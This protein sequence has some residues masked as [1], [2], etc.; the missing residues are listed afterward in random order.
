[1]RSS[2]VSED[3]TK[4]QTADVVMTYSASSDERKQ[5]LGRLLLEHARGMEDK[6]YCMIA[7]N[8]AM[9]QFCVDA[10]EIK[11]VAMEGDLERKLGLDKGAMSKDLDEVE[12]DGDD[13][14]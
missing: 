7:Q 2:N 12:D 3:I 5:G 13:D 14:E 11:S 4:V 1:V 8:Y 6:L 10:F 9:G